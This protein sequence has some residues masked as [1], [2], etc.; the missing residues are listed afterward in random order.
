MEKEVNIQQLLREILEP[1]ID[2][3]VER[4]FNKNINELRFEKPTITEVFDI[5]EATSYLKIS[6][7]TIYKMTMKQEI[8]HYKV[9][10]RLYFRKEDLD[11]WINK[12]RVKT[13]QEIIDA[14]DEYI[15]RKGR[16]G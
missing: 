14:A 5:K 12:G 4:A 3:C 16:R 6:K 15:I 1:I 2:D 8:P 11:S 13:R 10:K 9:G 7:A